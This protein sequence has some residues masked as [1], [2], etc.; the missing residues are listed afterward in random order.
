MRNQQFTTRTTT[1]RK[2]STK[3][4]TGVGQPSP[5]N[6]PDIA[7]HGVYESLIPKT[8]LYTE[9]ACIVFTVMTILVSVARS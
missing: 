7:K 9:P 1:Q 4:G 6:F 5:I 2:R 8:S 3:S